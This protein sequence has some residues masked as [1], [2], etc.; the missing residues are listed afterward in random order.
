MSENDPAT[1]NEL[2]RT[3]VRLQGARLL[4][5]QARDRALHLQDGTGSDL[6]GE[7]ETLLQEFYLEVGA[8]A[9]ERGDRLEAE[10]EGQI[11]PEYDLDSLLGLAREEDA[12]CA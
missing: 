11:Q 6:L 7:I 12:E 9:A 1:A 3:L 5:Q 10:G 4:L 8:M 2:H